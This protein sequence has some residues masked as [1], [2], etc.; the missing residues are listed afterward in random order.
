LLGAAQLFL[1]APAI[2][3]PVLFFEA[4]QCHEGEALRER[5]INNRPQVNNLPHIAGKPQTAACKAL[6]AGR[7]ANRPQVCEPAPQNL[8]APRLH[9]FEI[10]VNELHG[11]RALADSRCHALHGTGAYVARGEYAWMTGL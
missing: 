1:V 2:L 11:H 7:F 10:F 6:P 4:S 5:P 9:L 3:S 8:R